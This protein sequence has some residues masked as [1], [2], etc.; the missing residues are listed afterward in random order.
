VPP[1]RLDLLQMAA[2]LHNLGNIHTKLALFAQT[3]NQVGERI[4]S[5][6][7]S[8]VARTSQSFDSLTSLRE[9]FRIILHHHEWYNGE[10]LP[11]QLKGEAIPLESRILCAAEAFD[12]MVSPRPYRDRLSNLQALMLLESEAGQHFDPQVVAQMRAVVTRRNP[13]P[14]PEQAADSPVEPGPPIEKRRVGLLLSLAQTYLQNGSLDVAD[15]AFGDA[16]AVIGD[17]RVPGRAVALN[18]RALVALMRNLP[19]QAVRPLEDALLAARDG[20]PLLSARIQCTRVMLLA[21]QNQLAAAGP[22]LEEAERTFVDWKSSF[23]IGRVKLLSVLVA[24]R[25]RLED[26]KPADDAVR[27][28]FAKALDYLQENDLI[29]LPAYEAAFFAPLFLTAF[30]EAWAA[31]A[32][33]PFLSRFGSLTLEKYVAGFKPAEARQLNALLEQDVHAAPQQNNPLLS[34][35][36]FGKF[37]IFCQGEEIDDT[38]WRTRKAK[39][40]FAYLAYNSERDVLDEKIMD[41]FWPEYDADKARQNFYSALSH[42]RR[43]FEPSLPA[44]E[45]IIVAR[46]R[47]YRINPKIAF[48]VD[49]AQFDKLWDTANQLQK[50]GHQDEAI[51]SFERAETLYQG[52]FL[53]GYYDDWAIAIREEYE[54]RYHTVL[55]FLMNRFV[56]LKRYHVVQDY[57]QRLLA[58]DPCSQDAHLNLMQAYVAL[59]RPEQAVRQ[60]DLCCKVLKDELNLSPSAELSNLYLSLRK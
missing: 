9:V 7:E 29:A 2:H 53:E 48:T 4:Q 44:E 52:S 28:R 5:T 39:Y 35:Y 45:K 14:P 6:L 12:A 30:R 17:K 32:T 15:K 46:K 40:L 13:E 33:E 57:A 27:T 56:E 23:D 3:D 43:A 20:T 36:A 42:I 37:R 47:F 54:R 8:S 25:Q 22:I 59:G 51:T 55:S 50:T 1:T 41:L 26:K 58:V 31:G 60:Y 16:L 49:V 18:G 11:N 24:W 21:L 10:G 38:R 34:M 19:D